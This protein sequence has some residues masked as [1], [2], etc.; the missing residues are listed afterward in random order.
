MEI[1]K[2]KMM[3]K[4][5]KAN[6]ELRQRNKDS[7]QNAALYWNGLANERVF[8]ITKQ[9]LGIA[10]I[11]LPLTGTFLSVTKTISSFSLNLLVLSWI[12]LFTSII[13]GFI[14]LWKEASYFNYLS[15]DSSTREK[16]WSDPNRSVE[17]MDA[18]TNKIGSTNSSSSFTPLIIQSISLLVGIFLI[19]IVVYGLLSQNNS[20]ILSNYHCHSKHRL[21]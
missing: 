2:T 6:E 9:L 11:I 5:N 15:N 16:I 8:E 3:T 19:M 4:N 12:A 1:K 21:C 20:P 18:E 17:E 10:L 7:F 14:N 13:S